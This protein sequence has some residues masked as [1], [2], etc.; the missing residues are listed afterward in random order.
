MEAFQRMQKRLKQ[1]NTN[2]ASPKLALASTVSTSGSQHG[3]RTSPRTSQEKPAKTLELRPNSDSWPIELKT[4]IFKINYSVHHHLL[5]RYTDVSGE[6]TDLHCW[7]YISSG[8]QSI[9]GGEIVLSLR[10]RENEANTAYP[11]DFGRICDKIHADARID[12]IKLRRWR[13][14]TFETPLFGRQDFRAIVLGFR[15]LPILGLEGLG[16]EKKNILHFYCITITKEELAA[17]QTYGLTRALI[18]GSGHTSWFPYAPHVD[19]DRK[20]GLSIAEMEGSASGPGIGSK[21]DVQ[22]LNVFQVKSDVYLHIP[23]YQTEAFKQAMCL[24][25][26]KSTRSLSI[27][28][29]MHENCDSVYCWRAGGSAEIFSSAHRNEQT[30]MNFLI[31]CTGQSL[32]TIKIVEDGC[33]SSFSKSIFKDLIPANIN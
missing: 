22:G 11:L 3:A 12:G 31:L 13:V 7:T 4:P 29:E 6:W 32:N 17:A 23:Q 25:K 24:E 1:Y 28:S 30:A 15:N 9:T 26:I 21:L 14:I 16:L 18:L 19:R 5:A 2:E 20:S 10:R 33:V 8:L 27:E